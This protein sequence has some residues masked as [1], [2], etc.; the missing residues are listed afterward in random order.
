M[1]KGLVIG[2][3]IVVLIA[4]VYILVP[5]GDKTTYSYNE[6]DEENI[7]IENTL[8][9]LKECKA[10]EDVDRGNLSERLR[11][12]PEDIKQT[13]INDL[14]LYKDFK[15]IPLCDN[16]SPNN[17]QDAY[18]GCNETTEN[19]EELASFNFKSSKTSGGNSPA[20]TTY[21][22]YRCND[23][24]IFIERNSPPPRLKVYVLNPDIDLESYFLEY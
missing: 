15:G 16:Y 17:N 1:K 11:T 6:G 5:K 21:N 13:L 23:K 3:I 12:C 14:E 9:Y 22:F 4:L 19:C 8:N 10:V 7:G 2:I 20:F 18:E 24:N